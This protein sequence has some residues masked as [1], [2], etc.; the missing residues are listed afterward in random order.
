MNAAEIKS[1]PETKQIDVME[2][3]YSRNERLAAEFNAKLTAL[4]VFCVNVMGAPGVGKTSALARIVK[5][6]NAPA[7]VIEGDIE[8]D[9]DSKALGAL[10]IAA[11]QINTGG[12]CHLEAPI[13]AKAFGGDFS[14][15]Y[16]F[17]ENIGNLVCPAE[18]M[19]G[20]HIK[21]LISCVTEGGDKPYKYPL[22]FEKA[23]AILL[24]KSDLLPYV[25]FDLDFFMGG[26]RKLNPAAPVFQV[27]CKTGAGVGEAV[28]WLSERAKTVIG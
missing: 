16:L 5:L 2:S 11:T 28:E 22:A 3:V 19:I 25:D 27:S 9:I 6:L 10:G 1:G 7:R 8:S 4:R 21:L 12:A 15:G 20:E 17:I 24:N 26:V 14:D 23:D 13:V 18:F